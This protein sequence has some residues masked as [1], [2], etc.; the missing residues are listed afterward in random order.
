MAE[1]WVRLWAGMTTDP[2]LRTVSRKSGRPLY[3]VI[4]VFVHLILLANDSDVRGNI[5]DVDV[6]MIASALDSNEDHINAILDAMQSR[7]IKAG[8]IVGW[9]EIQAPAENYRQ[10][11]EVWMVTRSRI[12]KRDNFVCS[13]CG[14]R[15]VALECDHVIPI[16]QGGGNH[17]S[18]LTTACRDCNR[19]KGARTPEQWGGS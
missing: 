17:D 6:E 19:K 14:K 18:N 5:G 11:A 13:Y 16:A 12:F 3:E 1:S 10:S 15:G 4:A 9:S 2:K 8:R 7:I